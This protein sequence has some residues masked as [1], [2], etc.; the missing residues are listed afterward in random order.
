MLAT[1]PLMVAFGL[2]VL[3]RRVWVAL[4]GSVFIGYFLIIYNHFD[5]S[6]IVLNKSI[7]AITNPSNIQILLLIMV[8]SGFVKV[9]E[10]SNATYAL[11]NSVKKYIKTKRQLMYSTWLCGILIFFTDSGNSLILGPIFR[12]LYDAMGVCR[13]KLAYLLD[14]TSSPV[15]ILIPFI[16]WGLY[17][18]SLIEISIP[19]ATNNGIWYLLRVL[20]YQFYALFSLILIPLFIAKHLDFSAMARCQAGYQGLSNKP[21]L[22]TTLTFN[23]QPPGLCIIASFS[24]FFLT[25]ACLLMIKL[26]FPGAEYVSNIKLDLIIAYSFASIILV[27]SLKEKTQFKLVELFYFYVQGIKNIVNICLILIL[28]WQLSL[29]CKTLQTDILI[30]SFVAKLSVPYLIPAMLFIVSGVVSMAT[31]S[32]WGTFSIVLPISISMAL[33]INQNLYL[34]IGAVLS[35]GLF[36]DHCSPLSDTTILS[37]MASGCS[38][39]NHIRTQLPFAVIVASLCVVFYIGFA[40][41]LN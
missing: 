39:Y 4:C 1:Y 14:S 38:P 36:G 16:G 15:C 29:I 25:L 13:E 2:A 26:L 7:S 37:A 18:S 28:A 6:S 19:N 33:N 22:K 3:T 31:G 32:S 41:V 8:I 40:V 23:Q 9:L 10:S 34:M 11:A 24:A 17:I 20:P 27:F 5:S 35:G 21:K 12:P 30:T